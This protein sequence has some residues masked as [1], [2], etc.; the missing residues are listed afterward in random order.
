MV[1][2]FE[3]DVIVLD[4]GLPIASGFE[5]LH[6]LRSVPRTLQTPVIAISGLDSGVKLARDNPEFFETLPKPF[7]PD[8]LVRIVKR[9]FRRRR[10]STSP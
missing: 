6:E 1:D 4:L 5:V 8:T 2:A 9:A 3:P 7:E 10:W